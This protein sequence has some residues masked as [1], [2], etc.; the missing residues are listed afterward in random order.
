MKGGG[1]QM[2]P[3]ESQSWLQFVSKDGVLALLYVALI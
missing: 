3:V 2:H 1:D